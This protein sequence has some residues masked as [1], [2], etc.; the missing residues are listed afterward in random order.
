M[1]T[2]GAWEW[3][4]CLR[5]SEEMK[6]PF[7]PPNKLVITIT[8]AL[9]TTLSPVSEAIVCYIYSSDILNINYRIWN[10]NKG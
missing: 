6:G 8:T 4:V 3:V 2:S 7:T 10:M 1:S 9:V 5:Q